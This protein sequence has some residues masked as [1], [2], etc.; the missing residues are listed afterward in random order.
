MQVD[1]KADIADT[2]AAV[3]ILGSNGYRVYR[4]IEVPGYDDEFFVIIMGSP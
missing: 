2:F 1:G 3:E 4:T